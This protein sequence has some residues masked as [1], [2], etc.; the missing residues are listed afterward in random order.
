MK[1]DFAIY[2]PQA[3]EP[4]PWG[5]DILGA[6]SALISKGDTYPPSIHP[7]DHYFDWMRGR[8][9]DEFQLLLI[10]KG[11]GTIETEATDSFTITAPI[12]FLLYPGVWHRY[13]PSQ[14]TGWHEH[15][16]AF[17]GTFADEL[18]RSGLISPEKPF[19]KTGH[20]ETLLAQVQLIQDEVR[21]EAHGYR[22]IAAAALM[23]I[24]ALAITLPQRRE[25]ENQ[26]M[27]KVIRRACFLMRERSD[28]PLMPEELAAELNIGYTYFRRMFRKFT[29]ISPNRYHAQLRLRRVKRLLRDT[30]NSIVEIADVLGFNSPYH[31]SNWF[32]K[33]T[34]RS[35]QHWRK[36]PQY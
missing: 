35:P 3:E 7:S 18:L 34:G 31:L 32:K 8:V 36:D 26:P 25:E 1:T 14:D 5:L 20:S 33:E 21:A 27:R 10:T 30:S 16:I 23:Q 17:R 24:L 13:R 11:S 2:L 12:V 6:G 29:G 15:W 4:N 28:R 9:L 19:H 22:S